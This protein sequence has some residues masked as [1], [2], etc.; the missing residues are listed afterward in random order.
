MFGRF[1]CDG[2]QFLWKLQRIQKW[3]CCVIKVEEIEITMALFTFTIDQNE[4]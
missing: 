4:R 2:K 3:F 1:F